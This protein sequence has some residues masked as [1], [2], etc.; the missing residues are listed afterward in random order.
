MKGNCCL[1][2]NRSDSLFFFRFH[3]GE[4]MKSIFLLEI[5]KTQQSVCNFREV[6]K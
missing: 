1:S 6:E 5:S 2:L 4:R 3:F